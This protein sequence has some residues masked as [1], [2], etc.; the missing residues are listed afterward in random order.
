[1]DIYLVGINHHSAPV[2]VRESVAISQR[3]LGHYLG[4][5]Q[6]LIK[7][8]VLL[9]TCNRTEM[10]MWAEN[11][12]QADAVFKAFMLQFLEVEPV[13]YQ[14]HLYYKE[15]M[16]TAQHLLRVS[17]GLE[18]MILGEHE[19]IGQVRE[20]YECAKKAGTA[21][22]CLKRLFECALKAGRRVREETAIS[23]NPLSTS[24]ISVDIA[25]KTQAD[26]GSMNLLI[27]GSGE[28]G[29]LVA[30]IASKAGIG[31]ITVISRVSKAELKLNKH[32][33][34]MV[35]GYEQL[36]TEIT[37]SD[38]IVA[39]TQAP[40]YVVHPEQLT[41]FSTEREK[42]ALDI[43][44]IGVPR[45][46]DPEI[47]SIAGV[48]LYN[49]D[50]IGNIY[51]NNI[52]K[53]Q[54]HQQAAQDIIDQELERFEE[55]YHSLEV[56]PIIRSI[57]QRAEAIRSCQLEGTLKELKT[58]LSA[59][60]IYKIDAMTRAIVQRILHEPIGCLKDNPGNPVYVN[61]AVELFKL[62][63]GKKN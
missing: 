4:E 17:A 30:K 61:A 3:Q 54:A 57:T 38:V 53:R 35:V 5:L 43:I 59:D 42:H 50:D 10:Y 18:S 19:I 37:R 51:S 6:T 1:M 52:E 44:D 20:A 39:C 40:H 15:G 23:Q 45:N 63:E 31:K 58:T 28:A 21:E 60:E 14:D 46:V 36:D 62:T 48:T 27:I 24:S 41:R 9:S 25:L 22:L 8:A 47:Q 13:T 16:D 56:R 32:A 49:I 29:R 34:I 26:P 12:Q 11:I 55:F 7:H 33:R 2:Q